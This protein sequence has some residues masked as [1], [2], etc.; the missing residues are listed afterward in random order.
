MYKYIQ[1]DDTNSHFQSDSPVLFFY[2]LTN[3]K[4][5]KLV[6]CVD[7]WLGVNSQGGSFT[8]VVTLDQKLPLK[9]VE[10]NPLALG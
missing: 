2:E 4:I 8:S 7:F 5:R 6:I 10:E 1:I 3:S 9:P